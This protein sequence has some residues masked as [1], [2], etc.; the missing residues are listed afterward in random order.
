MQSISKDE[1][2]LRLPTEGSRFSRLDEG[3]PSS[4]QRSFGATPILVE[5]GGIRGVGSL[6][7]QF[8]FS[9][10]IDRMKWE[11][12]PKGFLSMS[13]R[14]FNTTVVIM[15]LATMSW[16]V[17]KKVLPL[18]SLGE[19]PSVSK[20]VDAQRN[21]PI[22]GWQVLCGQRPLGWALTETKRQPTG[23]TEI[24][25]RV[26]L[27]AM[28]LEEMVPGWFRP[29][30]R[31]VGRPTDKLAMD[32]RSVETVD[33]LGHLIRFDSTL[34]FDPWNEVVWVHGTVEGGLARCKCSREAGHSIGL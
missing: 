15:W 23:L 12:R 20:I 11:R 28:S 26:H 25:G 8:R 32:A 19:P 4:I 9:E 3:L 30:S 7:G 18:L 13:S 10:S 16:L 21:L 1:T 6:G 5:F 22:V 24:R 17:T 33:P 31:I 27:D 34:K 29:L 2:R 14:W